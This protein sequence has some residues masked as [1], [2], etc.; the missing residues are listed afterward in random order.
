MSG[1]SD[2]EETKQVQEAAVYAGLEGRVDNK[3]QRLNVLNAA[4][5]EKE[6]ELDAA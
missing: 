1:D 3:L 5:I 2:S 4:L 6:K